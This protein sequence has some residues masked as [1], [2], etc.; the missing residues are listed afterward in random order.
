MPLL[1]FTQALQLRADCLVLAALVLIGCERR[2]LRLDQVT[3]Q[4]TIATGGRGSIEAVKSI[5]WT[6][7]LSIPALPPMGFIGRLERAR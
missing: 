2:S 7:T 4:N 1:A 5:E 3:E 6:F